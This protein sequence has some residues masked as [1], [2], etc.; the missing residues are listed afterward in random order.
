MD[1]LFKDRVAKKPHPILQHIP[2]CMYVADVWGCPPLLLSGSFHSG[3]IHVSVLC[4]LAHLWPHIVDVVHR[5][6]S[7]MEIISRNTGLT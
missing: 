6:K 4:R 7:Q 2:T 5:D 1:I 3:D